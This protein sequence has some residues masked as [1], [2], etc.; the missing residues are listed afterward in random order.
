MDTFVVSIHWA[1]RVEVLDL[2]VNSLLLDEKEVEKMMVPVEMMQQ[3]KMMKQLEMKE[4]AMK[5]QVKMEMQEAKLKYHLG[6]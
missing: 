6:S 1:L 2:Q 3:V 4:V 5:I